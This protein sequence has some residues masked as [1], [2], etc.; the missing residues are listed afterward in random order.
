[1]KFLEFS[2]NNQKYIS[3]LLPF[4]TIDSN[5]KVLIYG[6]NPLGYQ[7]EPEPNHYNKIKKYILET[8][9]FI[10]PTS[11]VLAVDENEI[12]KVLNRELNILEFDDSKKGIEHKILRIVDGQH[13]IIAMREA[14]KSKPELE[15]FLFNVIILIVKPD[16]RSVEMEIFYDINSK[17]KRLKVDLIELARFN[18]RIIEKRLNERELNEHIA[19]QTAYFLNEKIE[20]SVWSNA[21]KFGIHDE[22]TIGIIGVNAFRE[23]IFGIVDAYIKINDNNRYLDLKGDDLILYS[24]EAALNIADF[25]HIVWNDIVKKKWEYCF[26][27][28]EIVYDLFF[29]PKNIYYSNKYYI[30]R[31]MG[32]KSINNIVSN[33]VNGKTSDNIKGLNEESL[34]II[35][36][37][38]SQSYINQDDWLVGGTFSGYSS[39]S[40]FKKVIQFIMNISKPQRSFL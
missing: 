38:I 28:S 37:Y 8:K 35:K 15:N 39:E 25:L 30:Q 12:K 22:Q 20:K 17:G 16:S 21:I 10:L 32:A 4:K 5:S 1:M 31:T 6:E 11:I 24:K 26:K 34:K 29:E 33:I 9:N 14:I 18:Y 13:R 19:I 3:L 36:T 27:E 2:Q 23:S 40:G 7:R